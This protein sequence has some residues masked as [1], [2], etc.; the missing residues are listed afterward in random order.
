MGFYS[1]NM[2]EKTISAQLFLDDIMDFQVAAKSGYQW[3]HDRIL[4]VMVKSLPMG[5][6]DF[7]HLS[8]NMG[9]PL[10]PNGVYRHSPDQLVIKSR[11][12]H[13]F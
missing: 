10:N 7:R 6:S 9:H 3:A 2:T 13:H 4:P 1:C 11:H 8:L 5:R 12:I